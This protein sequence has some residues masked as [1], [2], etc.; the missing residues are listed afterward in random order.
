[1]TRISWDGNTYSISSWKYIFGFR[2]AI[3]MFDGAFES[4]D[5]ILFNSDVLVNIWST[6]VDQKLNKGFT[7]KCK[8]CDFW[9]FWILNVGLRARNDDFLSPK[10]KSLMY[11]NVLCTSNDPH[12]HYVDFKRIHKFSLYFDLQICGIPSLHS[13]YDLYS[14]HIGIYSMVADGLK[15]YQSYLPLICSY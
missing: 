11:L 9:Q 3:S 2:Y 6:D 13:A 12:R 5:S 10:M 14:V 15:W 1:M 8:K 4:W 7:W